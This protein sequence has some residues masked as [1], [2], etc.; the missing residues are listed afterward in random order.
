[1]NRVAVD[2]RDGKF[3]FF[4]NRMIRNEAVADKLMR[5]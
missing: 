5:A 3:G 2:V 4:D 1:V